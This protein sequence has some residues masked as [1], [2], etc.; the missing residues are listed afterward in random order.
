MRF[1]KK[2]AR[3]AATAISASIFACS[4]NIEVIISFLCL[5]TIDVVFD[6]KTEFDESLFVTI[7]VG[8]TAMMFNISKS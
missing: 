7:I 8:V 1:F 6:S 2:D 5:L 3:V 4:E